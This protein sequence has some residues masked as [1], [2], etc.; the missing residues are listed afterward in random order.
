M[1]A[2]FFNANSSTFRDWFLRTGMRPLGQWVGIPHSPAIARIT[3]SSVKL[4]ISVI[5]VDCFRVLWNETLVQL[6]NYIVRPAVFVLYY[7]N[8][9]RF[10][11]LGLFNI[12]VTPF[13]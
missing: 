8:F 3:L 13:S 1:F 9:S 7:H 10:Y 12:F 5:Y 11:A 6:F 4:C 2:F